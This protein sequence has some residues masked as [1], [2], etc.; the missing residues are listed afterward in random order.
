MRQGMFL[1]LF[2]VYIH[3]DRYSDLISQILLAIVYL[4]FFVLSGA[5]PDRSV[6][7][8]DLI[9]HRIKNCGGPAKGG[10]W[11]TS[12]QKYTLINKSELSSKKW[13]ERCSVPTQ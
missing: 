8:E 10:G 3:I 2:I 5:T 13:T 6:R 7:S 9:Q 1:I 11:T 12:L 4:Y